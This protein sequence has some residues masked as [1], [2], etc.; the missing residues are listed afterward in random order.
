M[1][2]LATAKHSF[3]V[4]TVLDPVMKSMSDFPDDLS[5]AAYDHV[6]SL[7]SAADV[8]STVVHAVQKPPTKRA[9]EDVRSATMSFLARLLD[10][11]QASPTTEFDQYLNVLVPV[12]QLPVL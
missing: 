9:R 1:M 7:V 6:R 3:V 8:E 5:A 4:T 10:T 11:T 2:S 12:L